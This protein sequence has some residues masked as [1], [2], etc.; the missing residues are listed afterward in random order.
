VP[1]QRGGVTIGKRQVK[2]ALA[3]LAAATA[4]A[5]LLL[6]LVQLAEAVVFHH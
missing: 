6:V 2:L 3:W 5:N 4:F 1:P